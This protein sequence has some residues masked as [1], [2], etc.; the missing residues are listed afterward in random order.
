M[1]SRID[2]LEERVKR[3]ESVMAALLQ[4]GTPLEP[5]RLQALLAELNAP[6]APE[7]E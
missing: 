3:L 1:F 7:P 6:I 4:A 5:A 2:E